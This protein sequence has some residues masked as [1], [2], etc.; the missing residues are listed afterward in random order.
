MAIEIPVKPHPTEA[1]RKKCSH[2]CGVAQ[3]EKPWETELADSHQLEGHVICYLLSSV[4]CTRIRAGAPG[5]S[6]GTP[7]WP[8]SPV[9]GFWQLLA[10]SKAPREEKK[11]RKIPSERRGADTEQEPALPSAPGSSSAAPADMVYLSSAECKR[12]QRRPG[13]I[14]GSLAA[15]MK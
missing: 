6:V 1:G 13:L 15:E 8:P 9:R 11:G 10:L 14:P 4:I 5:F 3:G 2:G 7:P 12:C